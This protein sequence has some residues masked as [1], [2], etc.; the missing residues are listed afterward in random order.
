MFMRDEVSTRTL[1]HEDASAVHAMMKRA[2]IAGSQTLEMTQ[3]DFEAFPVSEL[4][5]GLREMSGDSNHFMLGVFFGDTLCGFA[6]LSRRTHLKWNH[7]SSFHS[8]YVADQESLF[9]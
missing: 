1:N 3:E 9:F 2:V 6:N 5:Y 4:E 7:K 8:Y